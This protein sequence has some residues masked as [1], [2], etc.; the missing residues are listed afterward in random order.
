MNTAA[1]TDTALPDK[2]EVQRDVPVPTRRGRIKYPI[3]ELE[4]GESFFIPANLGL[5]DGDRDELKTMN[6]LQARLSS[7][8][9]AVAENNPGRRFAT[10]RVVEQGQRGVRV[11][12]TE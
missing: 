1:N 6:L 11:W 9:R 4:V 12:R 10:R 8:T 5:Q 3:A 7:C 2:V